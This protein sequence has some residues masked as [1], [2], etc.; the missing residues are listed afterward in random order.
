MARLTGTQ[1]KAIAAKIRDKCSE[2]G[3]QYEV[4]DQI[5]T[6]HKYFIAGD[7]DGYRDADMEY[8]W[9]INLL[10]RSRPGSDWGTSGDGVGGYSAHKNGHFVM[11]RSGG[12]LL[13]LKE[14]EKLKLTD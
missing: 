3:W 8:Y 12:N 4:R 2:Y 1:A 5:L 11:N 6:I 10:P 14:L 9:I 7:L 13:I